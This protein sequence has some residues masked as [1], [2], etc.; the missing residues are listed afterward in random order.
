MQL[1]MPKQIK[2]FNKK[3]KE[4]EKQIDKDFDDDVNHPTLM[5]QF[6]LGKDGYVKFKDNSILATKL[7]DEES[8]ELLASFKGR[9]ISVNKKIHGN[10]DKLSAA[11]LENKWF[12]GITMQYHKHIYPGIMKHWRRQGY[13]NEER[14]T[15]EKGTNIALLDFIALPLHKAKY[16]KKLKADKNLTNEQLKHIEGFQNICKSY[17]D[18]IVNIKTYYHL[19]PRHE[20]ANILRGF[21]DFASVAVAIATAVG[22]QVLGADDDNFAYNFL[23]N[24]ADRLATESVAVRTPGLI[25]EAKKLWSSP[26]AAQNLFSDTGQLLSLTCQA[27]F[28]GEDFDPTYESGIYKGENKFIMLLKRNTPIVHSYYMLDRL[29][30]NNKTYK[31]SENMLSIINPKAIA[32]FITK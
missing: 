7:S 5:S 32:E 25:G 13:F 27:L 29:D 10:Y 11:M 8:M 18:F 22:V 14:G 31:L 4:V 15:V 24:Q 1:Y 30:K 17:L 6:E 20:Q 9:V 23:L 19:L 2:E 16:V 26:I 21:A 12:G 28:E 3:R